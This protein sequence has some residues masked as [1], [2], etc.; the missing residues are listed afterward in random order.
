M[1]TGIAK[2]L[3]SYF[4]SAT[5]SKG[6][7]YYQQGLVR[8]DSGGGV[9]VNAR[10][11]GTTVYR[12]SFSYADGYLNADC[13]CPYADS[14]AECKHIW[15]VLLAS[16][17][18][19]FLDV[20]A[21]NPNLMFE[22]NEPESDE[23]DDFDEE[24]LEAE[25]EE[26]EEDTPFELTP[27]SFEPKPEPVSTPSYKPAWKSHLE[28]ITGSHQ[29]GDQTLPL[30]PEKRQVLYIVEVNPTLSATGLVLSLASRDR[31]VNGDWGKVSPLN[32]Q[33]KDVPTF[34]LQEDR[35]LVSA[36]LGARQ[37]SPFGLDGYQQGS[38]SFRLPQILAN[39]VI[40]KAAQT[41]RFFLTREDYRYSKSPELLAVS[42]DD[43]GPWQLK[44][45]VR[46]QPGGLL[47][48][49]GWLQRGESRMDISE[50]LL[51]VSGGFVF[52]REHVAPLAEDAAFEWIAHL[53]RKGHIQ[54]PERDKDEFL[55]ALL[56]S[57]GVPSLD[58][59]EDLSYREVRCQP[60]P[61][62]KIRRS[63]RGR[64]GDD[65]L[66]AE[67]FFDYEG[68]LLAASNR[69][70]G[71]FEAPSRRLIRRDLE[72]EQSS[73]GFLTEIGFKEATP[74]IYN[75]S[76]FDL[77]PAKLPKAVRALVEAG[78]HI[79]ADGKSFRRPG[80]VQIEVTSGVDWFEM[81]GT[82]NYGETS[83][84]LPELLE[85]LK[86]GDNLIRL[87]DGSYGLLPEEW[88]SRIGVLAGLGTAE[89]G[90]VRFRRSQTGLLDALLAA[91]PEARFDEAF[92][93]AREELRRFHGIQAVPQPAGF[94]GQ[95]RDY[96][97]E[98]VGWMEF[99]R[100][101]S[102]GGCLADDM[103][104]GK[105]AQVLALLETR[106]AAREAG[107][108]IPPSLVVVPRSLVFNWKQEAE[109]FTPLLRVLDYTGTGRNS[110]GLSGYDIVLSTYGTLRRDAARLKDVEFDY[111]ILDEAQAIKN[112]GTES[113]KAVRLLKAHNRLAMSGTPIENH[114]G[115][116]WSLFEFLNP[117]ML[118]A[119]SVFKLAGGAGRNP[120][121]ETR[122]LLGHALRPFIL[123]RTKEQVARE[124]PAKTEQTIFCELEP[125]QRKLYNELRQH[126]RDSLLQRIETEGL[127]KS[128]IQVLEA[129]LRLRQAACHPGLLDP[130]RR[131]E[132]S[133]KID[134]LVDQ[135]RSVTEEGHK[136]LVFSQF[137]TLLGILKERLDDAGIVYEYLDGSTRNRQA[138]VD[139]FQN[140]G[141]CPVFLISLKAG[142]LGLNLTAAEYVFL[143]DPWWNPAVEA[144]AVDRAHRIGQTR[145]VF[146]YRL[147]ARDTVEEKVLALQ[148]SKRD[149]AAAIIGEDNSVIRDLRR[150]DLELLLS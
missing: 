46:R 101:F 69:S 4:T 94:S 56:T 24:E 97:R 110:D 73:A 96:Q 64:A 55:A 7:S 65:R 50:P 102:F 57:P 89:N 137:T 3:H 133:A 125:V 107:E 70:Q 131:E 32:V 39:S 119:A 108:S 113:A 19:G 143:L 27:P 61:I 13:E 136:A 142:G 112:S 118:G 30:Q 25:T 17:A 43:A 132:G 122:H 120:N 62:L 149:L 34:R 68:C 99:L 29:R 86:R 53:R 35:E 93:H 115:E 47:D 38:S 37:H 81:R 71:V 91:Q 138:C 15:A 8:I 77:P 59:P 144:Q 12:V 51:I 6:H 87:D 10:V 105:T 90:H 49:A 66:I 98:G 36:I 80:A 141:K 28:E 116:L 11:R 22:V 78:W 148:A 41:G 54:A 140:D 88:M 85:A 146:A 147:I 134:M 130:K 63:E 95:L 123:R 106:R 129:L 111:V 128:K 20:P 23:V 67:L 92:A 124:L 5:R 82:V 31:K 145:N 44:L 33:S 114:L 79:E 74:L 135:L 103:G 16:E 127:A 76:K 1:A 48:L 150:E 117:G 84:K 109:R 104:V 121:E 72:F 100:K 58:V 18:K 40:R 21:A 14:A 26:A 2:R 42:W 139:R 75:Q 83:A 126:Y 45:E 9:S 60:R 52:T